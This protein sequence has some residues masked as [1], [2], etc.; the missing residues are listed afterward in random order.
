MK[1]GID[2]GTTTT[3]VTYTNRKNRLN[4]LQ[5]DYQKF[6]P[7]VVY[8]QSRDEYLIGQAAKTSLVLK[9]E[10]GVESFKMALA[11]NRRYEITAENGDKFSIKARDV[12]RLFLQKIIARVEEKLLKDFGMAE[13]TI[14][15]AVITVPVRSHEKAK[16]A[17][18]RAAE[19]CGLTQVRLTPEPTAAAIAW[20]DKNSE[21][22]EQGFTVLV[23]DFGGGTFDV[24]VIQRRGGKF[25]E[26]ET[27]SDGKLGGND[28]TRRIA[29]YI[30]KK[31]NDEY[32][33]DFSEDVDELDE[34]DDDAKIKYIRNR[35]EIIN[36]ANILK[37]DL[38]EA[39]SAE[40]TINLVD[41]DG[42]NENYSVGLT[43]ANFERMIS[44]DI[45]HTVNKTVGVIERA[46]E[47]G[48]EKIDAVVL[49]GGSS[50]VPLI[51]KMLSARLK[52]L[53]IDY[54]EDA[55]FLISCGAA[56][57]ARRVEDIDRLTQNIAGVRIGT[58]AKSGLQY[59]V[60]QELI[61]EDEPLPVRRSEEFLLAH[62]GQRRLEIPYYTYDV[63]SYPN[64]VRVD[65][66]G[67]EEIDKLIID[68]PPNL[69]KDDTRVKV[70]FD[71]QTDGTMQ[72]SAEVRGAGNN[73]IVDKNIEIKRNSD[74]E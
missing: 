6:I 8:F 23:Y 25:V 70:T 34:D 35:A 71:L 16:R 29:D 44:K 66:K 45:E 57:L 42:E 1:I 22:E 37:E 49:A 7:S 32:G 62:D 72:F 14:E 63:K 19:D 48:V 11:E 47:S 17:T 27:D 41:I 74:L 55:A 69:K 4:Q 2:F 26:I 39:S 21:A 50:S 30:F 60:F 28:L 13:G 15:S 18:R 9:A 54:P 68:L 56:I 3:I 51:R 58:A 12:A 65:Q 40:Q 24:S 64:S 33:A 46:R 5:Y 53:K 36:K 67:I 31:V 61:S 52:D 73:L 20:L 38:S 43:R 59:N 10:A